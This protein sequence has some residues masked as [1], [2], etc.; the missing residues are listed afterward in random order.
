MVNPGKVRKRIL[1][2]YPPLCTVG[3][4]QA[5][6]SSHYRRALGSRAPSVAMLDDGGGAQRG[7]AALVRTALRRCALVLL[8]CIRAGR[9]LVDY[10]CTGESRIPSEFGLTMPGGMGWPPYR[11]CLMHFK[12][13]VVL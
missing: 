1:Y 11:L 5:I 12:D 13:M 2:I 4:A 9:C 8:G 7:A 10:Y 3:D 6:H